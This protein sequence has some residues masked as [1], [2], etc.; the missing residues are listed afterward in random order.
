MSY[1]M[2]F[3]TQHKRWQGYG[4]PAVCDHP[5]CKETI[6]RGVGYMCCENPNNPVSCGGFFCDDH[7]EV[8]I[9]HKSEFDDIEDDE[10][11]INELLVDYD[12]QEVPE[13]DED[14]CFYRCD[15][16]PIEYKEHPKWVAHV[17]SDPTWAQF[18]LE[19]P[20]AFKTM[21]SRKIDDVKG[22]S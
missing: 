21:Q 3:S 10:D 9:I 11:A 22:D 7:R 6:I 8:T 15:H 14:D 12:L 1:E 19:D 18:R 2:Y 20:E 5:G 13:F 16:S 17:E 4:V